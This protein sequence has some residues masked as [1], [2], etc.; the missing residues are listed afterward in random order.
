MFHRIPSTILFLLYKNSRIF[1]LLLELQIDRQSE[2]F[3][4][5]KTL[6]SKLTEREGEREREIEI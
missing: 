2:H 6:K 3:G 1:S 5:R 4:D